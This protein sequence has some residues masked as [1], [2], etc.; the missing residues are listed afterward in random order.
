MVALQR[1]RRARESRVRQD[2]AQQSIQIPPPAEE[3]S[4]TLRSLL[5]RGRLAAMEPAPDAPPDASAQAAAPTAEAEPP[6]APPA[7][8]GRDCEH[9]ATKVQCVARGHATRKEVHQLAKKRA[10]AA[11]AELPTR[12][13][14]KTE[15]SLQNKRQN[16]AVTTQAHYRGM[17][18][19]QRL[20]MAQ[21]SLQAVYA[22]TAKGEAGGSNRMLI[23][24]A[25][26]R[27]QVD[28]INS[29]KRKLQRV[30]EEAKDDLLMNSRSGQAREVRR[31]LKQLKNEVSKLDHDSKMINSISQ[32]NKSGCISQQTASDDAPPSYDALRDTAWT[33]EAQLKQIQW[34]RLSLNVQPKEA[35]APQPV[36]SSDDAVDFWL[37]MQ[38]EADDAASPTAAPASA[39]APAPAA[40]EFEV[41]Y[42]V[43]LSR[44][45]S[46]PTSR[47]V[48]APPAAAAAA[49]WATDLLGGSVDHAP[50]AP[51]PASVMDE[52]RR[53]ATKKVYIRNVLSNDQAMRAHLTS[54]LLLSAGLVDLDTISIKA[55]RACKKELD[56]LHLQRAVAAGAKWRTDVPGRKE[57]L[58]HYIGML[59]YI[60]S[61]L[62]L[63]RRLTMR[64]LFKRAVRAKLPGFGYSKEVKQYAV[65]IQRHYRGHTARVYFNMCD[66]LKKS[67]RE[68]EL[69]N[70]R[71]QDAQH[72]LQKHF[73]FSLASVRTVNQAIRTAAATL[74]QR[75]VRYKWLEREMRAD[76]AK[77]QAAVRRIELMWRVQRSEARAKEKVER[78]DGREEAYA[79]TLRSHRRAMREERTAMKR[80][81]AE[82]ATTD[83]GGALARA[84]APVRTNAHGGPSPRYRPSLA[85]TAQP[86]FFRA[87]PPP[88]LAL[89]GQSGG[90]H[91]RLVGE[92][93]AR[94]G[95]LSRRSLL[96]LRSYAKPPRAVAQVLEC[97][98]VLLGVSADWESA[99]LQLADAT[100]LMERLQQYGDAGTPHPAA[101]HAAG[102]Y[103]A[104]PAFTPEEVRKVSPAARW[105]CA[106]CHAVVG[107][108]HEAADRSL[109]WLPASV[110][111]GV[112][113]HA[114]TTASTAS[115]PPMLP[116][117][118]PPLATA[119]TGVPD[120]DGCAGDPASA[121]PDAAPA[122]LIE[123]VTTLPSVGAMSARGPLRPQPPTERP[124][125]QTARPPLRA[126]LT[127]HLPR[128]E[129][130]R[131]ARPPPRTMRPLLRLVA[132]D[133]AGGVDGT[134][135]SWKEATA[136]A[137][138]TLSSLGGGRPGGNAAEAWV[139]TPAA[140]DEAGAAQ[141]AALRVM[142]DSFAESG[143]TVSAALA[144]ARRAAEPPPSKTAEVEMCPRHEVFVLKRA[145]L[146]D[147]PLGGGRRT[148]AALASLWLDGGFRAA[149][150]KQRRAEL[151]TWRAKRA[152]WS[153]AAGLRKQLVGALADR[154]AQRV[155]K[156]A[157][158]EQESTY[159][160]QLW[161]IEDDAAVCVQGW[162]RRL[163]LER[164]R[165]LEAHVA[166][167]M[168]TANLARVVKGSEHGR[169]VKRSRAAA[170]RRRNLRAGYEP[171][172]S[173]PA[174]RA[175]RAPSP[176][177]SEEEQAKQAERQRQAAR[178]DEVVGDRPLHEV[179]DMVALGLDSLLASLKVKVAVLDVEESNA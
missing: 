66:Q 2:G 58:E 29:Q 3:R 150:R 26:K 113:K 101:L 92:A 128:V 88:E 36:A 100:Y 48:N 116:T 74:I 19:R 70:E 89:P 40:G 73:S 24:Q 52:R 115:A 93:I 125:W 84:G 134:A 1:A 148:N 149:H 167:E 117:V 126:H 61:M 175:P 119:A 68:L 169:L 44:Q 75:G 137:A 64:A 42:R 15:H 76:A 114:E 106:W 25:D 14:M 65:V 86:G 17:N 172:D 32:P 91:A 27:R 146:L 136:N 111:G 11:P 98:C 120:W 147:A 118:L 162:W 57:A 168:R 9:A 157:E 123:S 99:K 41:P 95:K 112:S 12:H 56:Q 110:T 8:D 22:L 59:D 50:A 151:G 153:R 141:A 145:A 47:G 104:D 85:A 160:R 39:P 109:R 177:P 127:H 6:T 102:R 159:R 155:V 31:R 138:C 21:A 131:R 34:R 124:P 35:E 49:S 46:R 178:I 5:L 163:Q 67:E 142:L 94:L 33:I 179:S 10:E 77:R 139:Q 133:G 174:V 166:I 129:T 82:H 161:Q 130:D 51:T 96:E 80:A 97:T 132:K 90:L 30:I 54:C 43:S 71:R 87:P 135:T 37:A 72:R 152:A 105:L 20:R 28:E 7:V 18:V 170:S 122:T 158:V 53:T 140:M 121:A 144:L 13:R 16:A 164:R 69:L 4:C 38:K 79:A 171:S 81:V 107:A 176:L 45:G 55:V 62:E 154:E 83:D 108:S 60:G 103:L 143:G 78:V 156:A 23:H 165:S 173:P 63:K